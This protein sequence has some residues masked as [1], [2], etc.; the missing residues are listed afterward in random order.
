MITLK[1]TSNSAIQIIRYAD[2]LREQILSVWEQS[3]RATH[4]FLTPEDFQTIKGI[5]HTINF[6]DFEVYC[7]V[8]DQKVLGFTGIA[9]QKIEMLFLA[10]EAFGRGLGSRLMEFAL[11]ELNANKVDVNEQNTNAVKFYSKWGFETLERTDKDDLGFDYPLL[12]MERK[13]K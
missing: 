2:E 7:L 4:H 10:P 8:Q 1:L 6:N 9:S 11:R 12:R 13:A 3:V 5:V